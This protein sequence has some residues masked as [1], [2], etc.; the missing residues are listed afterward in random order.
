[1]SRVPQEACFKSP[2]VGSRASERIEFV[3]IRLPPSLLS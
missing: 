1:V 3:A 2:A